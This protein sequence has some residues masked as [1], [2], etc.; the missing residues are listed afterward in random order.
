[1]IVELAREE[2]RRFNE[3]DHYRSRQR[4]PAD[5]HPDADPAYARPQDGHR[6]PL[7]MGEAVDFERKNVRLQHRA[8]T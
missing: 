7:F 6:S 1:M 2:A 3:A 4:Q 5:P 8:M